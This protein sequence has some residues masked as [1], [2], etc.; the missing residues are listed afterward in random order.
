MRDDALLQQYA[1]TQDPD[2]FAQLVER[3][4][5]LVYTTCMRI[6]RDA[7]DAQDAAQE[8]FLSLAR[9]AGSVHSSLA[10]W[11]HTTAPRRLDCAQRGLP[12]GKAQCTGADPPH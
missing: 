10:G 8:C 7:H 4:S 1:A 12:T 9:K 6:T 3:Y 11:L 2:A 5:D